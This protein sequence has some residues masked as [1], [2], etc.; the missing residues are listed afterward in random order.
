MS[1]TSKTETD[2]CVICGTSFPRQYQSKGKYKRYCSNECRYKA[3]TDLGVCDTCGKTYIHSKLSKKKGSY[4][5]VECTPRPG[6]DFCGQTIFG[7]R[8]NKSTNKGR[9]CSRRCSLAHYSA[10]EAMGI[11]KSEVIRVG[12][13][14]YRVIG[15]AACLKRTGKLACERCGEERLHAL[16]VHHID[17]DHG[18]IS[19][20]NLEALC[21]SCHQ[22]EHKEGSAKR[23]MDVRAA[24]FLAEKSVR[25][26]A[27]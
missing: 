4:C 2:S 11:N 23:E 19:P 18:N 21:A 17:R 8:I 3:K 24:R 14:N 13:T 5:S 26:M 20:E 1:Y 10:S 27:E 7:R 22:I 25:F 12:K 6:C 9:F 15:F 16:C